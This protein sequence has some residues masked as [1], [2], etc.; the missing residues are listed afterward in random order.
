MEPATMP[1]QHL[2]VILGCILAALQFLYRWWDKQDTKEIIKAFNKQSIKIINSSNEQSIKIIDTVNDG[3]K[4][5]DPH[6]ER[7]KSTHE[8]IFALHEQHK[9]TDANGVPL[10]FRNV[11]AEN[12][13]DELVKLAHTTTTTQLH[14]SKILDKMEVKFDDVGTQISKHQGI[15]TK[16]FNKLK[17]KM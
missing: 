10:V 14:I 11:H 12:I 4:S 7:T 16:Q 13:M 3:I 5:F 6:I 1:N 2:I 17:E 9:A 8:W 15:C